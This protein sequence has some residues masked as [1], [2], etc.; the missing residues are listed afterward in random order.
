[1]INMSQK[2]N[3]DL[4]K[5]NFITIKR[6]IMDYRESNRWYITAS[7]LKL[8][9]DSPLLYK[10]VYIDEVDLSEVKKSQALEIW[11]MVDKYLLTP[12]EFDKEYIFPIQW[13]LKADLINYCNDNW[14]KLKWTEKVDDLKLLVYWGK[15]VL[16]EAQSDIVKWIAEEMKRQPLRDSET[17]YEC[18][19]DLFWEYN[20]LKIKWTLDRFYDDWNWNFMIRDLKTTSQMFY[21]NYSWNTQFFADLSTRDT[22]HYK[23]Q[24]AMYVWLVRQNFKD[25]KS[26]TVIIDAVWTTDP[27]FYQAIKFN[28]DELDSMRDILIVPLLNS[29]KMVDLWMQMVVDTSNRNKLCSNWYYKLWTDDCIQKDFEYIQWP[30]EDKSKESDFD[31]NEL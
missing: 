8:F 5:N 4:L 16:T 21:N 20:W 2:R 30:V 10:A 26:I 11:S 28:I 29:I 31:W 27:Y 22:Y 1:M 3:E 23:L 18:Q 6:N 15:R 19:K 25:I 14:I 12:E 9:L 17:K 13:W 24:M 7:K